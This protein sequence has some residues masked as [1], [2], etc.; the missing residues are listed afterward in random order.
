MKN[1]LFLFLLSGFLFRVT[2]QSDPKAIEIIK[3]NI[4]ATGGKDKMMAVKSMIRKMEISMPFGT[5][6]S[7][8]FYKNGKFYSK[9]TMGGNVVMEQKYDGNRV[10]MNGMQGTQTLD[11]EKAVKRMAQQGKIFP[12]LD[13]YDETGT[14]LKFIG[15]EKVEG[16]DCN[17]VTST[18]AEGNLTTLFYNVETGL[19]SKMIIKTEFQG[20]PVEQTMV[21][22]DYKL[23]D[24]LQFSHKLTMNSGQF[25]MEMKISEIKL[26]PEIPDNTF[27]ID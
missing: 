27:L 6:E 4:E 2:A 5:S 7:E 14:T 16:K 24:G 21:F 1:L 23:V 26:N 12:A 13:L 8:S 9:S 15:V 25:N 3:K 10:Y 20:N 11:D 18:D 22:G 19:L 17:K